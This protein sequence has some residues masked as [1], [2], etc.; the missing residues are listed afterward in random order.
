MGQIE[1]KKQQ[2]LNIRIDSDLMR[3]LKKKAKKYNTMVSKIVRHALK[4]YL[5]KE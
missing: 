4:T 5:E 2:Y 1:Q 3:D